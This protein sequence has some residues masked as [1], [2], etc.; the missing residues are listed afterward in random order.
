MVTI[1]E[2]D[3]YDSS[4]KNI[5]DGSYNKNFDTTSGKVVGKT[6]DLKKGSVSKWLKK[7]DGQDSSGKGGG[8]L[9]GAAGIFS[10]A[11]ANIKD[12]NSG[13]NP[14]A[15]FG[16]PGESKNPYTVTDEGYS[17]GM[18]SSEGPQTTL[19]RNPET[20]PKKKKK[21]KNYDY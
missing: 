9:S 7:V 4:G 6:K 14:T 13:L 3:L 1:N 11:A 18:K 8:R 19:L 15:T 12:S 2:K 21:N 20:E 17:G 10:Q 16:D 5:F